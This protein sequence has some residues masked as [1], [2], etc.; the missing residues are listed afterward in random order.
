MLRRLPFRAPAALSLSATGLVPG[1]LFLLLVAFLPASAEAPQ[2]RG[3]HADL[4]L[5]S[6]DTQVRFAR[7]PHVSHGQLVFSYHGDLWIGQADGS[8]IR[9]LTSH[10]AN[11]VRPRFSPDG[12]QVAFTSNRAGANHVWVVPAAGGEPRQVTFHPAGDN[13]QYWTPEGDAILI[14]T[15]RGHDPFRTPLHRAPLDGS[16]PTP[17]GMDEASSGM[18]RQ[19]GAMVAFNRKGFSFTRR[20]YLGN[21]AADVWVQELGSGSFR[22]LTNLDVRQY[23]EQGHTA[24]PMWGADG[25][26]YYLAEKGGPFNLWRISPEGGEPEQVTFHTADGVQYPSI[27][28]DGRILSYTKDF[29]I[30]T[31][32]LEEGTPRRVALDMRP[33]PRTHDVE[34]HTFQNRA[35]G[36]SPSPDGEYLAVDVR[37]RIFLVPAEDGVGEKI[38]VTP[39]AFRE[40]FHGWSPDGRHLAFVS[41][42][43]GEEEIWLHEVATG[44]QRRLTNH[45]S[46]KTGAIWSPDSRR[47]AFEASNTLFLV[48]VESG[49]QEELDFNRAGGFSLHGFSPDGDWL[50]YTRR[51]RDMNAEVFLREIATGREIDMTRNPWNN[52]GGILTPDQKHLLFLSNRGGGPNQLWI[53]S[54]ARMTEDPDDPLVREREARGG[55]LRDRA[56]GAGG[57]GAASSGGGSGDAEGG[58]ASAGAAS[59]SGSAGSARGRGGAPEPIRVD[60]DG[61]ERR[62][63]PLTT[64]STGVSSPFLSADGRTV[65]FLGSDSDGAGL[66]AVGV[67]G[68]NRRRVAA[69]SFPGLTPSADGR[70]VFFRGASAGAPGTEVH[71]MQLSNQRRARVDF[72]L[73][74]WV[75]LRDE[76]RQIFEESWRVMTYRFYDE[77]MHGTDW[78]GI[79]EKYRALLPSVASYDDLHDVA[80]KML[81][82]LNASHLGVS[83]PSTRSQ[84]SDARPRYLGFE[85]EPAEGGRYQVR[86][87]YPD[88]P[89]DHE[90]ID[91]EVG[92]YVLALDGEELHAGDNYWRTLARLVNDWVTVRVASDPSGRNARELRMATVPSVVNLRYEAWV[93]ANRAYVEEVSE[94]RIAYVHI[95]AMNQPSLVRFEQ[96]INRFWNAEGIVVDVRFN[97]GGN[98]DQQLIDILERQ[99]YQFWNPRWGDVTWGRRPRQAI[100]GPKVML[101]NHRSGSDAEVT[102]LGFQQLGLGSLVGNPTAGAVIATGSYGLLHGGSIRTPG[103]LVV[104]WDPT[105]PD[106]QGVNLE[107]LGVAPDV[108]VENTPEDVLSGFDRELH[109][110]VEEALRKLRAEEEARGGGGPPR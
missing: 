45:P 27:S 50:V 7:W 80:N 15:S 102:P 99:P 38:P 35:D 8:G 4:A 103:S 61:L 9:R 22:Q 97:G 18:I 66:F 16:I 10:V 29:H 2:S 98:I 3:P 87:V 30:W 51:D 54:L 46:L 74:I 75:E 57:N 58:A 28:P 90:W 34:M 68:R 70:Y 100:A 77:S 88:G 65:Y 104:T 109:A 21:N 76:W 63:R 14:S 107:N 23:Q 82:E 93:E 41:D 1:L 24:L 36:F 101:I 6:A 64:G 13:V 25:M 31:L 89:A 37:G 48:E 56:G 52:T 95:R 94:G 86:Y 39:G 108:W 11:D 42:R 110:A 78:E 91:L 106:N 96:E 43:S 55:V 47:L 69:G 72:T 59:G 85:M 92:D 81:G 33:D 26:V 62:A 17:L 5:Q 19:D 71:R 60:E 49:R 20:G 84:P 32:E 44:S 12:T 67:D 53:V 73:P 83:G 105:Q 40:R 79:R